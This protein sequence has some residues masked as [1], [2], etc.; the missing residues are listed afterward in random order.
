MPA[1]PLPLIPGETASIGGHAAEGLSVW[2]APLGDLAMEERIGPE[3]II[4]RRMTDQGLALHTKATRYRTSR[5]DEWLEFQRY[6]LMHGDG[7]TPIGVINVTLHHTHQGTQ[8]RV[9]NAFVAVAHR[10]QGVAS[11][12]LAWV[13]TDHPQLCADS[14]LTELGAALTGQKPST[15][16]SL[17]LRP[18]RRH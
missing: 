15:D 8:A 7:L 9:S 5:P 3:K 11:A 4:E 6:L 12:L 14:S 17:R 2:L 18:A 10:R 13:K 1:F 16:S